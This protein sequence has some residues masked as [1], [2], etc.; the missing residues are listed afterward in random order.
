MQNMDDNDGER[1]HYIL[2]SRSFHLCVSYSCAPVLMPSA[3]IWLR[4]LCAP[5]P[6]RACL[7]KQRRPWPLRRNC[8]LQH[9]CRTVLP[10]RALS[11]M[12]V[13]RPWNFVWL[14]R[15]AGGV[16]SQLL[17]RR[18]VEFRSGNVCRLHYGSFWVAEDLAHI[19]NFNVLLPCA[20]CC[21][22]LQ[23]EIGFV[24][25]QIADSYCLDHGTILDPSSLLPR[26]W[27]PH[28]V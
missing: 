4:H 13:A 1:A 15:R 9:H 24:C 7:F 11:Y 19:S 8:L 28:T 20:I 23:M 5:A 22:V 18:R 17:M 26:I 21:R 3:M 27:L 10:V 25:A 12:C 16:V 14:A 2:R 6:I